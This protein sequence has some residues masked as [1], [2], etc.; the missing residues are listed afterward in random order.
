MKGGKERAN[1]R[2]LRE[3][4]VELKKVI[5][6]T[7]EQATNLTMIVIAI[8]AGVGIILGIIDYGFYQIFRGFLLGIR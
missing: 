3:T 6:P 8:S 1:L 4:W 5:W 7:R 2:F